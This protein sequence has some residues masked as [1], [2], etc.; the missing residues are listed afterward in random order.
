MRVILQIEAGKDRIVLTPESESDR[1]ILGR[2]SGQRAEVNVITD[3]KSG[4]GYA[5]HSELKEVR[6]ELAPV[7]AVEPP[8]F[9]HPD[10]EV[11]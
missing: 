8:Q 9:R 4:Y 1:Q 3:W 5:Q 11:D 6:I 2:F 7:P 10:P